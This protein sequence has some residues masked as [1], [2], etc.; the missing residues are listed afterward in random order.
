MGGAMG[1]TYVGMK[2]YT[3]TRLKQLGHSKCFPSWEWL[4]HTGRRGKLQAGGASYK[5]RNG[6]GE[7]KRNET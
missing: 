1:V 3:C 7:T 6:N 5:I 4:P 2:G